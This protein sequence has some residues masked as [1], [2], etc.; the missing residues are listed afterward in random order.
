MS[1][2]R[3]ESPWKDGGFENQWNFKIKKKTGYLEGLFFKTKFLMLK[4]NSIV[5]F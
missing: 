1:A 4:N 2:K 5:M 3:R